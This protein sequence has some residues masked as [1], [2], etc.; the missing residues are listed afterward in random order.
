M[1]HIDRSLWIHMLVLGIYIDQA[2]GW[3]RLFCAP[4]YTVGRLAGGLADN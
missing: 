1:G 4:T 3:M 2:R